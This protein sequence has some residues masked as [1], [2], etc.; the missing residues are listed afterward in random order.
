MVLRGQRSRHE[1]RRALMRACERRAILD[2]EA[3]CR[4]C[5]RPLRFSAAWPATSQERGKACRSGGIR[6]EFESVQWGSWKR[7]PQRLTS[8]SGKE[9]SPRG[10]AARHANRVFGVAARQTVDWQWQCNHFAEQEAS[11]V[12]CIGGEQSGARRGRWPR[13]MHASGRDWTAETF[14]AT[15]ARTRLPLLDY[16]ASEPPSGRLAEGDAVIRE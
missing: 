7:S 15:T 4:S 2:D 3:G 1:H 14:P 16:F 6:C 11:K 10:A 12:G 9:V 8:R 5:P 13:R